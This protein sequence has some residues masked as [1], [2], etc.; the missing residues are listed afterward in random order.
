[1]T[2]EPQGNIGEIHHQVEIVKR[3]GFIEKLKKIHFK[4]KA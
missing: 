2:T 4:S 3:D 1:M